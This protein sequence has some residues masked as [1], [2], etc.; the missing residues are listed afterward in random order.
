MIDGLSF[1]HI[2]IACKDLLKSERSYSALGYVRVSEF[3]DPGLRVRGM[4]LEGPGP[5]LELVSDL[6][7]E[8][9][10]APWLT[11][12]AAMYH[13][14]FETADVA[15]A[16]AT[17]REDGAKVVKGPTSAVAFAGRPVAFVM[18]RNMALVE[19]I[20]STET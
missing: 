4:F 6:P 16:L 11:R 12:D 17:A 19:F 15:A 1:H 18:L 5:R 14:A 20:S 9:V 10:V 8:R 2:G 7:G 3:D 13:L